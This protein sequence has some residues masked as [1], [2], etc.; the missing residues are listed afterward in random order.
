MGTSIFEI[1]A[2]PHDRLSV[3]ALGEREIYLIDDGKIHGLTDTTKHAESLKAI[4]TYLRIVSHLERSNR[5]WD[6]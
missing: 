4:Q 2:E 3:A 6:K 1:T 5:I